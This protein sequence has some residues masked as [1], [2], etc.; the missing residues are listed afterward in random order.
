MSQTKRGRWYFR[1]VSDK[2]WTLVFPT[3]LRQNVDA[4]ISDMSQTK[5]G[6]WYFRHVSDKTS[7]LV[8]PTC[9]RQNVDAG[10]S[11][12]SQTKR[13][14]WY[15]RHVSDK[16][17]TLVFPRWAFSEPE[18]TQRSGSPFARTPNSEPWVPSVCFEIVHD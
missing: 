14:R 13:G 16:T 1:H 15:F 7:T 10:I 2:T 12:M 17:W 6:R 8:F 3:C 4:G 11:D 5:R 9:L 18:H